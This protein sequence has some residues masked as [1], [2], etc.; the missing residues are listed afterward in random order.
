MQLNITTFFNSDVDMSDIS[1][2]RMEHGDDAARITW[3]NA[4]EATRSH[5]PPLLDTEEKLDAMRDHVRG[6]GA[7]SR[8]ELAEYSAEDL[9]ALLLQFIAG[10]IRE[11]C[12]PDDMTAD[13]WWKEYESGCERGTY[14]GRMYRGDDG[15]VYYYLGE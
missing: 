10:D 12:S 8:D 6:F 7:W 9:N 4:K 1:G 15:L 13:S 14:A 2:S 3:N 11:V 5:V